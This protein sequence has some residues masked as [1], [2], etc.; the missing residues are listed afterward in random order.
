MM[1]K[2]LL[3]ALVAMFTLGFSLDA[4]QNPQR[5]RGDGQA[6]APGK[7]W[8]AKERVENMQK[9]LDLTA[10]EKEKVLALFEA[11]DAERAK[12]IEQQ[13]A[14]RDGQVQ[15]REKRREEMQALREKE[16][17]K[18]DA[19]LEEIIGKDKM[20]KWKEYRETRQ[21]EMQRPTRQAKG[22]R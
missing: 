10:V 12:Q 19:A 6:G 18:N 4:Q 2:G 20:K 15:D 17:A 11:Q 7:R 9:Q 22:Q 21:K 3:L 14:K 8:N 1:K 5:R 16:V 13:R